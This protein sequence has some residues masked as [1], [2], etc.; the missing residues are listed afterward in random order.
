MPITIRDEDE[1]YRRLVPTNIDKLG[2]V[3][4]SAY[5]LNG[6]PDNNVSVNLARMS[7]VEETASQAPK[8][9]AGVGSL[10]ARLPRSLSSRSFMTRWTET[11]PIRRS[12]EPA[13][14]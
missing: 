13:P 5:K 14:R 4:S 1:L 9:G 12:E 10:V 8:P 7:S 2:F 6:H 3:N 11:K